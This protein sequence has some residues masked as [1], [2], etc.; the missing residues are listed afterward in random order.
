MMYGQ[1]TAGS[2]IYIGSQGIVQGT[3]R[4]L[5]ELGRRH[6]GGS[7]AGRWILTAGLGGMAARS[8]SP[9]PWRAPRCW[10]S[11]P[12]FAHR[13]ALKRPAILDMQAAFARRGADHDC[14]RVPGQESR[15]VGV[16][17]NAAEILPELCG[18]A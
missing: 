9:P 15:V 2:W 11:I 14:A 10:R 4:D 5:R 12:A 17:A 3:I 1:M 13:D 7:L 16:S 18:A 6:Y 8:R